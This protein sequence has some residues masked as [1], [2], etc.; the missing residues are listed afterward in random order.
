MATLGERVV[1][2]EISLNDNDNDNDKEV[3]LIAA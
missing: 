2:T 3:A 1:E